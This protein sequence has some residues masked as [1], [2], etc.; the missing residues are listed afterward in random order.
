[1]CNLFYRPQKAHASVRIHADVMA[2]LK[3]PGKGYQTRM[4]ASVRQAM[5]QSL[6][7]KT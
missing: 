6:Q 4:N 3:S 2:W 5:M 7:H 1:V